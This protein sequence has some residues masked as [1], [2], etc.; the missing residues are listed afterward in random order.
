MS[1]RLPPGGRAAAAGYLDHASTAPLHPA[2]REAL[3]TALEQAW[4]D[5]GRLHAAGRRASDA[6]YNARAAVAEV[7]GCP[8]TSVSFPP[9]GSAAAA[10]AILGTAQ[11]RHRRGRAVVH[12]AVEHSSV[13]MAAAALES[14]PVPVE[15]TGRVDLDRFAAEVA[16]PGVVVASLQSANNE[17]GT[18][19]PLAPAYQ[20]CAA[21]G[22][23]LHVDAA[24][25]LG[26]SAPPAEWDLLTA[27]AHKWGGPAGVGVLAVRPGVRWRPP[28]HGPAGL[29]ASPAGFPNVPAVVAAA[30]ALVAVERERA[31][32]TAR[33][34]RL[35]ARIRAGVLASVPDVEMLGPTEPDQR[36]AHLVA[37]SCLY[38]DGEAL[39]GELD[40]A[41]FAV[42][43]GSACVAAAVAPS[44]VLEAMG[45]LTHGNVRVSLG[46][47][48]TAAEVDRFLRVLPEAVSRV[49][50]AAGAQQL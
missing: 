24:G 8:D 34:A 41:G 33:L 29:V 31:E 38:V 25:S 44:H 11:A 39:L 36:L 13:L 16:A 40:R 43:S 6:L 9:S 4:A 45:V 19:Q 14:R 18:C 35:T 46:R 47:D 20:A 7:L 2:A 48:T 42:G 49:R 30:A 28:G 12:S 10:S 26:H 37:F 17:V 32:E 27:S 3:L 22:V 50:A 5:P 1:T 23:S 15:G 21:A